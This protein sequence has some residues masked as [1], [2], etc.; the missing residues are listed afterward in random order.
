MSLFHDLIDLALVEH[1]LTQNELR[2]HLALMRQTIGYGKTQDAISNRQLGDL[3]GLRSDRMQTAIKGL[4]EKGL[5]TREKHRYFDYTYHLPSAFKP[6]K[7]ITPSLSKAPENQKSDAPNNE[8]TSRKS[9]THIQ[10]NL[11]NKTRHTTPEQPKPESVATNQAL[12]WS[13]VKTLSNAEQAQAKRLLKPLPTQDSQDCLTLFQLEFKLGKVR[14]PIAYLAAL[15]RAVKRGVLDRSALKFH[16][17]QQQKSKAKPTSPAPEIQR[18]NA[19]AEQQHLKK[20]ANLA[21]I[22]LE[23]LT[24]TGAAYAS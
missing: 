20:L 18:A 2:V 22:P 23:T 11:T 12:D 3:S 17:Y 5:W 8:P 1:K 16:R 4:I 21:N 14:K 24:G 10:T 13:C 7:I 19:Y 6:Q 15:V 9:V